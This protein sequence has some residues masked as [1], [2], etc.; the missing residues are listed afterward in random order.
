LSKLTHLELNFQ[1]RTSNQE[2]EILSSHLPNC[3]SLK[4]LKLMFSEASKLGDPSLYFLLL[5]IQG[6]VSLENLTLEFFFEVLFGEKA[7]SEFVEGLTVLKNLHN[8]GFCSAQRFLNRQNATLP[9]NLKVYQNL[10]H[11]RS[12]F[13]NDSRYI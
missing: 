13:V 11:L 1:E 2:V 12:F 8:I 9:R 7:L 5:G 6:L 3:Q 4:S 10:K